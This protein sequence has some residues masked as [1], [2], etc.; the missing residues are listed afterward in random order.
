MGE[1][2]NADTSYNSSSGGYERVKIPFAGTTK[3]GPDVPCREC[4]I[5]AN[6]SNVSNVRMNIGAAATSVDG[7]IL[8]QPVKGVFTVAVVTSAVPVPMALKIDNLNKL[9]FWANAFDIV[10]ILYRK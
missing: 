10:D 8:P 1:K 6:I 7:I 2:S 4:Y 3:T 9:Q 5:L